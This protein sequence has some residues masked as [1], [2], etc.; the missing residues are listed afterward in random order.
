MSPAYT[1]VAPRKVERRSRVVVQ[2][3]LVTMLLW[4]SVPVLRRVDHDLTVID[5]FVVEAALALDPMQPSDV[6]EVTGVPADAVGRIADRLVGLGALVAGQ[7][8]Y[9]ATAVARNALQRKTIPEERQA[10]LTFLYLP[11][12]DEL[13]AYPPGP[14]AA[15]P[16]LLQRAHPAG[17]TRLPDDVT[18]QSRSQF[19]RERLSAVPGLPADIVDTIDSPEL[20][21]VDCPQYRCR[22]TVRQPADGM[23][24]LVLQIDH[25]AGKQVIAKIVGARQLADR[26]AQLAAAG[27]QA[28]EAWTTDGG[29]VTATQVSP[30]ALTFELDGLAA[31]AADRQEVALGGPAGLLVHEENDVVYLEATFAAADDDARRILAV[32]HACR[33]VSA[34]LP[35]RVSPAVLQ[36]AAEAAQEHLALGQETIDAQDVIG[37]LWQRRLYQH[38]YSA[39]REEDFADV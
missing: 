20:M 15:N 6:E 23:P 11:D 9:S 27:S 8:G 18:A 29:K 30:T 12:T 3:T 32:H 39:R 4:P 25:E 16:P 2:E 10:Y 28:G 36:R 22:G 1:F 35:A 26:W 13:M 19:I 21:P 38:V 37:A 34:M 17:L 5:R 14:Q 24:E 31:A 33:E 7:E